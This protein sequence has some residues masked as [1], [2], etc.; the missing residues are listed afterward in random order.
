MQELESNYVASGGTKL[1]AEGELL[2][3]ALRLKAHS[4]TG[5]AGSVLVFGAAAVSRLIWI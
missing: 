4:A 2:T 3:I 1:I 5:K